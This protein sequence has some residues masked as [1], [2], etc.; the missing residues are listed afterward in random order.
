MTSG[1]DGSAIPGVNVIIKG[2][3]QGTVT[4]MNGDYKLTVPSENTILDFSFIGLVF[5]EIPEGVRSVIDVS[6]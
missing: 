1:E 6:L 2:T 5:Q 3:T 4:D